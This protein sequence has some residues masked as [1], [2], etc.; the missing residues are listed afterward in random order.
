MGRKRPPV[1]SP[2]G[3]A[4]LTHDG[5]RLFLRFKSLRLDLFGF[6]QPKEKLILGKRFGAATEAVALLHH[7]LQRV[8]VIRKLVRRYRHGSRT[9]YFAL[10]NEAPSAADSIGRGRYPAFSGTRA[11]PVAWTRFQSSPSNKAENW[12]DVRCIAP[13]CIRGQ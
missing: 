13:S 9:A 12:T 6:F 1:R 8:Q 2:F 10:Q 4:C 7:R 5:Q 3:N 11:W